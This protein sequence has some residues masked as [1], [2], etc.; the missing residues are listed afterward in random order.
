MHMADALV[1]PAVGGAMWAATA[2]LTGYSAKKLKKNLDEH[3]VPLMGV[4]GAFIFA[5]QMINFT[6]PAT[7]SSGHLGGGM[8]LAILLGPY[9]A[10]LVMASV[11][12]IQA[13]FFADGG[14]LALGCNIVNL[15]FFPCFIAYPLIY[16]KIAGNRPTRGRILLGAVVAAILGLQLGAFGVVLETWLSGLTELSF[17]SF[18]LLMQPI[19]LAIGIVEGLVTAA[20]VSFVWKAHPEILSLTASAAAGRVHSHKPLLLGLAL[21]AVFTGGALSWFASTHPDGLEWAIKGVT[22]KEELAAPSAGTHGALAWVQEKL[23]FL[24]DYDFKRPAEEKGARPEEEKGEKKAESW[25]EVSSGKSLAGV[26][27][28]AMT[29]LLA[30]VIGLGL[31]RYYSHHKG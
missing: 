23:A 10:F 5:A 2:S 27:G 16:R 18:L 24:P 14:L 25:P 4:L 28:A 1:S 13:L 30:G 3:K 31:R 22:G 9:A 19:H 26:L 15:G 20:V 29:L 7:G 11:L 17:T 21:F 8:I 6:I 12:T